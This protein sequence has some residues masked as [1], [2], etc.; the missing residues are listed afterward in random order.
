[1]RSLLFYLNPLEDLNWMLFSC[2]YLN[3]SDDLERIKNEGLCV[4]EVCCG[5][6][7]SLTLGKIGKNFNLHNQY[8]GRHENNV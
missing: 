7:L 1:M 2:L 5:G 4:F 8:K 6:G 3:S